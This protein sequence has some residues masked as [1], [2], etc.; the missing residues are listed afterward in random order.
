MD[1]ME[2]P[3]SLL[4]S[5]D[6]IT[7]NKSTKNHTDGKKLCIKIIWIEILIFEEHTS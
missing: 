3:G 4:F 7:E 2:D 6:G 1:R 5:S